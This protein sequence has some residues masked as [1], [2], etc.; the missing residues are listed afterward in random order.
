MYG[1]ISMN[2]QS[3]FKPPLHDGFDG[4][5][6]SR[7]TVQ[8]GIFSVEYHVSGPRGAKIGLVRNRHHPHQ[9]FAVNL[10]TMAVVSINGAKW[11]TD[12]D[13]FLKPLEK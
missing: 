3:V 11:W 1:E 13:G 8:S 5:T 6:V 7:A 4:Y 2:Q 12:R 10:T 9:L